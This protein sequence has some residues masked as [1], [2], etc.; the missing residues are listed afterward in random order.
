MAER[1]P[2]NRLP[3]AQWRPDEDCLYRDEHCDTGACCRRFEA[4]RKADIAE[5]NQRAGEYAEVCR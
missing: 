5:P 3:D 4:E 1:L 2:W